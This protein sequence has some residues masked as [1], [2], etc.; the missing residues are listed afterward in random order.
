MKKTCIILLLFCCVLPGW[1][2]MKKPTFRPD[3]VLEA[4]KP[5]NATYLYVVEH[6]EGNTKREAINQALAR[7]FQSTANRI[8]QPIN[9]E[10]FN[11]AVQKGT[12]YEVIS[13]TMKV[14]VNKVCEFPVQNADQTWT[15]YILCQVAKSGNITVEFET[16]EQCTRHERYD[17]QLKAYNE[18]IAKQK[19]DSI[20][21]IKK[22]KN[23]MNATAI[24]ASVFVPGAGQ[25][26]KGEVGKGAGILISEAALVGGGVTCYLVGK[27]QLDLMQ[28]R[29]IEYTAFNTAQK[30]YNAMRAVSYT[31]Y[32]AA[33]AL[34]A[35]N[36]VHAYLMPPSWSVKRRLGLD[37]VAFYP[38][39]LPI[40]E[41]SNSSYAM[42]AGVQF[43]F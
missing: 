21:Q 42:G 27:K 32:G 36:I 1:A 35:F 26:Y 30:K 6:G 33:A 41:F 19:A 38:T 8:G 2:Q 28:D 39:V 9:T 31:C 12:D 23:R 15:V 7:V 43:K 37:G 25:M 4:P 40:N 29:A 17:K 13:R 5:E 20:A 14:P 18:W 10:E 11:R 16:S 24:A 3:W 22:A 34:Y